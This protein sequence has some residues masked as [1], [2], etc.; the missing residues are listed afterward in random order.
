MRYRDKLT[1]LYVSRSTWLRS[2]A[3]GGRR[4]VTVPGKAIPR[5][6]VKSTK[7]RPQAVPVERKPR[8]RPAPK[9]QRPAKRPE[10]RK[11]TRKPPERRKPVKRPPAKK[12]PAKKPPA[13][14]LPEDKPVLIR[15]RYQHRDGRGRTQYTDV[16]VVVSRGR[17]V[18]ARVGSGR[19]SYFYDDPRS[20]VDLQKLFST[21][22]S[23]AERHPA[24]PGDWWD[25]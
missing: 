10:P 15:W 16:E 9:R 24:K 19:R 25:R 14:K 20:L 4:Y 21:M 8:K 23:N 18:A 11:P 5:P 13:R 17:V 3:Q 2:R 22:P 12:A 1:G 6:K 7:R